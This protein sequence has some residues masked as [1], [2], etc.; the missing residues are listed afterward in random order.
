MASKGRVVAWLILQLPPLPRCPPWCLYLVSFA[1]SI[2]CPIDEMA[3]F[4]F[5]S[6]LVLSC[7]IPTVMSLCGRECWAIRWCCYSCI[8]WLPWATLASL[9]RLQDVLGLAL[10]HVYID[11]FVLGTWRKVDYARLPSPT[12][13]LTPFLLSFVCVCVCVEKKET[14]KSGR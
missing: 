1:E 5:F 4:F 12:L 14:Q 11:W 6:R 13:F 7:M 8:P 9:N 2:L 10:I 3:A